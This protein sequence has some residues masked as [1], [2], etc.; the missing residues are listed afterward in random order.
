MNRLKPLAK[1]IKTLEEV[2]KIYTMRALLTMQNARL[3]TAKKLGI[4]E[5]TLRNRLM[6]YK[7]EGWKIP[8]YQC[9]RPCPEE[10]KERRRIYPR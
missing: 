8:H 3:A 1:E 9:S 7:T 5:V 10:E 6:Q 2:I 4:S